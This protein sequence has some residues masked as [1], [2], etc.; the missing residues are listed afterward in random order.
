MK[1]DVPVVRIGYASL[2]ISVEAD[3]QEEANRK[4]LEQAPSEDFSEHESEYKLEGDDD[5]G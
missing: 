5:N 1:F 2:T 3:S 4:A